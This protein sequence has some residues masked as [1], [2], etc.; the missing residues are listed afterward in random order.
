MKGVVFMGGRGA[1]FGGGGGS[2]SYV[3]L[4]SAVEFKD[5]YYRDAQ[6]S[7]TRGKK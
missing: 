4:N 2:P 6:Q 5:T 1:S 7:I 3:S